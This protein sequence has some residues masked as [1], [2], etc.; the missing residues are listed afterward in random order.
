ML[1]QI[2]RKRQSDRPGADHYHGMLSSLGTG[3]IL[4]GVA[5]VTELVSGLRHAL[6]L[7]WPR[8]RARLKMVASA[9]I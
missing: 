3:P 7:L 1:R 8:D 2:D 4:I 6:T 9:T 5:A